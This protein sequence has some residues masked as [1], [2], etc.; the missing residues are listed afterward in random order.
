MKIGS[1]HKLKIDRFTPQGVYLTD[2]TGQDVLLPNK[3]VPHNAKKED[4]IEVFI[5]RDSEDRII[6]TTLRPHAIVGEFAYLK[7][8]EV[9]KFGAFLDWGIEKDLLVPFRE[10]IGKMQQGHSY[11]VFLYLDS[12]TDRIAA[13]QKI[14][15]FIEKKEILLQEGDEVQLLIGEATELGLNAIVDNRYQGLIY[16]NEVFD[17][18]IAGDRLVGYVKKIRADKK[19][20]I[21]LQKQGLENLEAGALKIME[22]LDNNNG[23]IPLTDKSSPEE[24]QFELQMSKKNFKRSLGMI[25]K[26]RLVKLTDKGIQKL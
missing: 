20:D 3:Y 1:I 21:S 7:V 23:F 17:D 5:Y 2:T 11:L 16:E 26:K 25:Y 13:T 9:S 14:L 24:I 22:A 10:Q 19:L 8:K 15:P 18:V 4:T 6:A 12:K